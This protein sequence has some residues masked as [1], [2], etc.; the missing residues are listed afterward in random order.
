MLSGP[1]FSLFGAYFP[2]W[3]SCLFIALIIVLLLR[4]VFIRTGIDDILNFRLTA[5]T[6]MVIAIACGLALVVYGR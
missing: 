6:A 1:S 2:S 5:Y 3:M 4:A